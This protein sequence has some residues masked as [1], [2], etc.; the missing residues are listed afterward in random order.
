MKIKILGIYEEKGNLRV[1]AETPYG[2][3][4]IG[5]SLE[6]KYLGEDGQPKWKK[7]VEQLLKLKYGEVT[8]NMVVPKKEIFKEEKGKE[9]EI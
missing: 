1:E 8:K 3:E 2:I 9:M 6:S 5:L 7:Q 4:N